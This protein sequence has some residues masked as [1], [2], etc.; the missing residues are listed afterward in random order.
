[1]SLIKNLFFLANMYKRV[2]AKRNYKA[3]DK[4]FIL[5]LKIISNLILCR[6]P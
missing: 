5:L 1:M 6:F 2:K 4:P 3:S